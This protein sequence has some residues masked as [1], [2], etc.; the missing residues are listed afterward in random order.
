MRFVDY[1]L[2]L[3][4]E[5]TA[6]KI[7]MLKMSSRMVSGR[8]IPRL[9]EVLMFPNLSPNIAVLTL[10]SPETNDIIAARRRTDDITEK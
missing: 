3:T 1:G 7:V 9:E 8:A 4:S 10:S 6:S 5:T 2:Y